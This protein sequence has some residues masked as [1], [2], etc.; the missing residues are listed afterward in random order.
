M[1]PGR[2]SSPRWMSCPAPL[3]AN[4]DFEEQALE[5]ALQQQLSDPP[6]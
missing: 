6:V 2:T 4:L 5:P 3:L 1:M